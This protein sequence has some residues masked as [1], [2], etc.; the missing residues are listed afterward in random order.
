MDHTHAPSLRS[1]VESAED[2][3][4]FPI[5]NLP[6]GV[7]RRRGSDEPARVGMAIGDMI[8]DIAACQAEGRF[9][10]LAATSP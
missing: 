7:F 6:L 8:L 3:P 5:Q 10:G 9:T 4:D 1:W 2:H